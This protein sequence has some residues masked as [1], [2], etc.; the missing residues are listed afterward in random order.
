M[1]VAMDPDPWYAIG[2]AARHYE[3]KLE[4]Y[5]TLA[6]DYFEVDA[7]EEFCDRHLAHVDEAMAEYIDSTSSTGC[8]STPSSARSRRTST[9]SSSRTTA[10]SSPPGSPTRR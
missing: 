8:W 5:R 10:A 3:E 7:Y 2:D 4:G 1:R 9:S 6:D